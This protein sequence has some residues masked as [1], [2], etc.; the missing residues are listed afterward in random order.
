MMKLKRMVS[1]EYGRLAASVMV[2]LGIRDATTPVARAAVEVVGTV[3]HEPADLEDGSV[4]A[5][6]MVWAIRS[7]SGA[8]S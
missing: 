2:C 5:N 7:A 3:Y 1:F 6:R 8:D 4:A